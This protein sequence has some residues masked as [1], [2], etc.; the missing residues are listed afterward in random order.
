MKKIRRLIVTILLIVMFLAG[1]SVFSFPY[2]SDFIHRRAQTIVIDE[3]RK[4]VRNTDESHINELVE[5]ARR[6][7]EELRKNGARFYLTEK[8]LDE[9]RNMLQIGVSTVI[10]TIAIPVADIHLP[11]YS[12]TD[13][14][15]LAIG[16]GHIEGTSFPVGGAGTHSVITGH[17]GLHT[18]SLFTEIDRMDIGDT[19]LLN[20]LNLNLLYE[21]DQ[22]EI[23][24][25]DDFSLLDIYE[26]KDYV[27]LLTC[28]PIAVNTHRLL[29]RGVR[30]DTVDIEDML[31]PAGSAYVSIIALISVMAFMGVVLIIR[32]INIFKKEK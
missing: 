20:I 5:A 26:D 4:A 19:F 9:Y 12:G 2:V 11:I 28:T 22:I 32:L 25:P 24:L 21:V 13:D 15:V 27:T 1:L 6:Y 8:E 17:R 31:M 7:N 18:A 10:G 29:I 30:V 16:A 14:A 23:V 3:Y